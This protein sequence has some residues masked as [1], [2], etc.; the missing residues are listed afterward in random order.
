M[1][2]VGGLWPVMVFY[3]LAIPGFLYAAHRK[4]WMHW[5]RCHPAALGLSGLVAKTG[6]EAFHRLLLAYRA[7]IALYVGCLLLYVFIGGGGPAFYFYTVWNYTLLGVYF[8]VRAPAAER[9]GGRER[10]GGGDGERGTRNVFS[11]SFSLSFVSRLFPPSAR[12][13]SADC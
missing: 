5:E 8:I 3:M 10:G 2:I 13:V 12:V 1:E 9:E 7:C 4:G 11:F 6:N